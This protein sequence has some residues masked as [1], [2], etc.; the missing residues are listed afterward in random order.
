MRT[1]FSANGVAVKI[2]DLGM[3]QIEDNYNNRIF[4]LYPEEA[5]LLCATLGV[6]L[7]GLDSAK[8]NPPP[9]QL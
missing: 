1:K 6:V 7:E 9:D 5:A 8:S 3:I 2:D 4:T